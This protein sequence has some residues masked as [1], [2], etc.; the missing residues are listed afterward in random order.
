MAKVDLN[1]ALTLLEASKILTVAGN[2]KEMSRV[3]SAI[4]ALT[5]AQS[6]VATAMTKLQSA[7]KAIDLIE[8]M[9]RTKPQE[10]VKSVEAFRKFYAE[11]SVKLNDLTASLASVNSE[12]MA[13]SP[14]VEQ[15]APAAPAAPAAAP[16]KPAPQKGK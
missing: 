16:P 14:S 1:A 6:N 12:L 8:P 7:A 10:S 9:L 5:Q 4:R 2:P 11:I 3:N 15:P 13:L